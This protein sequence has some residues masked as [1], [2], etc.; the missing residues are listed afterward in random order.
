M[1][2]PDPIPWPPWLDSVGQWVGTVILVVKLTRRAA[3]WLRRAP[4]A[5]PPVDA[6]D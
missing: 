6:P 5:T 4:A 3:A 1:P 2:D